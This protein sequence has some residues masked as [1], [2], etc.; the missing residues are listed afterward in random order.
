MRAAAGAATVSGPWRAGPGLCAP[1]CAPALLLE[2]EP[3]RDQRPP[4]QRA[5]GSWAPAPPGCP[6][7]YKP[8][9]TRTHA[10]ARACLCRWSALAAAGRAEPLS[11]LQ[12][13]LNFFT[14]GQPGHAFMAQQ[15]QHEVEATTRLAGR[16][17][18][19]AAERVDILAQQ[20]EAAAQSPTRSARQQQ[21]VK[22]PS[23]TTSTSA[24][25]ARGS[26]SGNS[27]AAAHAHAAFEQ[28]VSRLT[29]AFARTPAPPMPSRPAPP[30]A[31][32]APSAPSPSPAPFVAP[33]PPSRSPAPT[34]PP[35]PPV[36]HA[37]HAP[38]YALPSPDATP[39]SFSFPRAALA[40][41]PTPGMLRLGGDQPLAAPPL[42]GPTPAPFSPAGEQQ[43]PLPQPLRL[44]TPPTSTRL[45]LAPLTLLRWDANPLRD[46][47]SLQQPP[48][49]CAIPAAPI[50]DAGGG[51]A[52]ALVCTAAPSRIP[53]P[54][55]TQPLSLQEAPLPALVDGDAPHLAQSTLK[56]SSARAFDA[57]PPPP[58]PPPSH[59]PPQPSR[60][61]LIAVRSLAATA[62]QPAPL[63]PLPHVADPPPPPPP[64]HAELPAPS[65]PPMGRPTLPQGAPAPLPPTGK[66]KAKS[67]LTSA[68][69]PRRPWRLAG[70][71]GNLADPPLVQ[72]QPLKKTKKQDALKAVAPSLAA[73]AGVTRRGAGSGGGSRLPRA[74]ARAA[75][76]E[77]G[78][79]SV[80]GKR[81]GDTQPLP[82]Q[83]APQR[84][85]A[86]QD[87]EEG[88]VDAACATMLR[89]DTEAALGERARLRLPAHGR[90]VPSPQR[91]ASRCVRR[92]LMLLLRSRCVAGPAQRRG[93]RRVPR[94]GGRR[95]RPER[96][97]GRR[98][99]GERR[100][101]SRAQ[102]R[103]R[104]RARARAARAVA[105]ELA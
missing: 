16:V 6:N 62:P 29:A 50:G 67:A 74:G 47:A 37:H 87:P 9:N 103:R 17:V 73:A 52:A 38:A 48:R 58:P 85:R 51:L 77:E 41:G 99:L 91:R 43:A 100:C 61:R 42:L 69:M 60:Q 18:M 23:P 40:D 53:R 94:A 81:K 31:P 92:H 88:E 75:S 97:G 7:S 5:P 20:E 68:L 36:P 24:A 66:P 49:L 98:D 14:P 93:Q 63:P 71:P 90:A 78:P 89:D 25:V 8:T 2:S 39:T 32:T 86:Q 101:R 10:F 70:R 59:T 11:D 33:P 56:R 28:P 104:R 96:R 13:P 45:Q 21:A 27:G 19:S 22:C 72:K 30:A 26:G 15:L 1:V 65:S 35:S 84:P 64:S 79:T 57:P 3:P 54:A 12:A 95:Q 44:A 34:A 76:V 102:G 4:P 105:A 55:A 82:E 80:L 46:E 83:R